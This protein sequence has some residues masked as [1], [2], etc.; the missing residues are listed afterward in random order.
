MIGVNVVEMLLP[1]TVMLKI[2][3]NVTGTLCTHN[4]DHLIYSRKIQILGES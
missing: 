2:A 1:S 3:T 4:I